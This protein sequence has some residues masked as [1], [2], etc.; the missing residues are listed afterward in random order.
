M[1]QE[2][3]RAQSIESLVVETESLRLQDGCLGG[4]HAEAREI[5]SER[6]APLV[7]TAGGIDVFDA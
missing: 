7:T 4:A 6:L 1:K 2:A 3:T 5:R